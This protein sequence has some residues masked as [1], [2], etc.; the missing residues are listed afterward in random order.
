MNRDFFYRAFRILA[1]LL[2]QTE[3]KGMENIPSQ[4][5]IV[6]A[7]NHMSQADSVLLLLNP[8]RTDIIAM[9]ADKYKK[10]L[11]FRWVIEGT[12]CIWLDRDK[13]DYAAFRTA[14]EAIKN[15]AAMGIAPEGTRSRNGQLLQGKPGAVLLAMRGD[16]PILPVGVAGTEVVMHKITHLQRAKIT[17]TF[18]PVF[19]LPPINRANREEEMQHQADEIMCRIAALLPDKYHGFYA[20]NPRIKEIQAGINL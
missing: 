7:L 8:K 19:H 15:G 18:G 12:G 20:G 16:V 11:L 17:L 4:G 5:G 1:R 10:Y 2:T 6:V 13:A 14:T 9:V 3:Y